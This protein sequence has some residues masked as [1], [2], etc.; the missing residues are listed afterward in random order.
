MTIQTLNIQNIHENIK[1]ELTP[2]KTFSLFFTDKWWQYMTDQTNSYAFQTLSRNNFLQNS[3][4]HR[5]KPINDIMLKKYIGI[6]LWMG[7]HSNKEISGNIDML[8][9]FKYLTR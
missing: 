2:F 9:K 6:L 8:E 3:R 5:W 1:D 4:V 7:I